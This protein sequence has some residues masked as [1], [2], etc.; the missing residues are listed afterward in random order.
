MGCRTL[1]V[2]LAERALS[3]E[4]HAASLL[5]MQLLGTSLELAR[6]LGARE[7]DVAHT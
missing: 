6:G 5:G 1:H 4:A 7:A 3:G 2:A